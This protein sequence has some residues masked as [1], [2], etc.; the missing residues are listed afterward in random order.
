MCLGMHFAIVQVKAIIH[1]ILVRYR[2][3]LPKG[4]EVQFI[5]IPIPRPKC[6]LPLHF[7]RL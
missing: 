1:Q 6:N 2:V 4:H 5:P 7:E 3:S